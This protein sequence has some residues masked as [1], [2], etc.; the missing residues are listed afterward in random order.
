VH[1][2]T[3]DAL[4]GTATVVEGA[5]A[6]FGGVQVISPSRSHQTVRWQKRDQH[7]ADYVATHPGTPQ[8]IR[9]RGGEEGGAMVGS[10]RL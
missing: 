3:A 9:I 4:S 2:I 1:G 6:R 5:A 8:H 10:A 7:V